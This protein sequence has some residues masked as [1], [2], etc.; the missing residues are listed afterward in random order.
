MKV[1]LVG[2]GHI[3]QLVHQKIKHSIVGIFDL[4]N[5]YLSDSPD[6]IVDFSNPNALDKTIELALK[7]NARV[8]LGTT[9]Y[10]SKQKERIKELSKQVSV[11]T[12]SNFSLG[13]MLLNKFFKENNKY[14]KDY[15]KEIIEI[16]HKNKVDSP[17]GTAK[18]I[19]KLIGCKNIT[20]IRTKD[21]IGVHNIL[22]FG[23]DEVIEIKHSITSR[24]NFVLGV[25]KAIEW[26]KDKEVGLYGLEDVIN[27]M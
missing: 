18:T 27:A 15:D 21:V 9:G 10:N 13:I 6:I 25:L 11:L 5:N 12:A 14:L 8:L 24:S 2:Y 17:S 3:N 1:F 22:F 23:S 19:A 7:Y 26:L 16:H 20:S 4:N